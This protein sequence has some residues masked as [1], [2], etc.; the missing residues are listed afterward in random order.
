LQFEVMIIIPS[1]VVMLMWML[2]NSNSKFLKFN[3]EFWF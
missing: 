1:C 2:R 3:F